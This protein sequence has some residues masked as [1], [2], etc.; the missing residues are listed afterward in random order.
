ML[1][2]VTVRNDG[3]V[4]RGRRSVTSARP[5]KGGVAVLRYAP[6]AR[7]APRAL[8]RLVDQVDNCIEQQGM[9]MST[10]IMIVITSTRPV[11]ET[12]KRSTSSAS[13][14]LIYNDFTG[15]WMEPC[16]TGNCMPPLF[17]E[18]NFSRGTAAGLETHRFSGLSR[19]APAQWAR[20][21]I[22]VTDK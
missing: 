2:T 7:S 11:W 13:K 8:R 4:L 20:V 19:N 1:D 12:A 10:H 5:L 9:G 17:P 15:P 21:D 3:E 22:R 18:R 16:R 14:P 6:T